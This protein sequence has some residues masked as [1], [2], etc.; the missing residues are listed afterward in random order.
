MEALQL[1]ADEQSNLRGFANKA[2]LFAGCVKGSGDGG[3]STKTVDTH[4]SVDTLHAKYCI[5]CTDGPLVRIE[6]LGA[7][8]SSCEARWKACLVC[9][10]RS[11]RAS[12]G[13]VARILCFRCAI[14][15]F[16][17]MLQVQGRVQIVVVR[18]VRALLQVHCSVAL[19]H[20][21]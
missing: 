11:A 7:D 14:Q 8:S 5:L 4:A 12:K 19:E 16:I 13:H 9:V 15:C 17:W 20:T 6:R 10:V 18:D 21:A 3:R 1:T 2:G